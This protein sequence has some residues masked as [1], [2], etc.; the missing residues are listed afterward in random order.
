MDK[1]IIIP[2]GLAVALLILGAA[3]T[4][5]PAEPAGLTHEPCSDPYPW[6]PTPT[7]TAEPYP[8]PPAPPSFYVYLPVII[9]SGPYR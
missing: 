9:N 6:P 7:P 2:L 4:T 1:R 3:M 8:W 5:A